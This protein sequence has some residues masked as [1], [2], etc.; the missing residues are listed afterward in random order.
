M[1]GIA[2]AAPAPPTGATV[3]VATSSIA[4]AGLVSPQ[5]GALSS[6][7]ALTIAIPGGGRSATVSI[8]SFGVA[9]PTSVV[10][11]ASSGSETATPTLTVNPATLKSFSIAPASVTGGT[12]A[13]ATL[14]LDGKA[15]TYR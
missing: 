5:L 9:S 1:I 3:S 7:S 13:I 10:I 2:V 8:Q 12:S 14:T 6:V 15:P 11:R 4:V